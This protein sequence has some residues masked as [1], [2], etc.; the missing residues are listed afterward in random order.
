MTHPIKRRNYRTFEEKKNYKAFEEE[1][2]SRE[3][4]KNYRTF[5]KDVASANMQNNYIIRDSKEDKKQQKL[6]S[7]IIE[8]VDKKEK[9]LSSTKKG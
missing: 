9:E 7:V 3:E 1:K 6:M 5:K 4:E 8:N 2:N